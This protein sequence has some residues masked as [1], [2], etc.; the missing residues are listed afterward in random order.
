VNTAACGG[1]YVVWHE[2]RY[3]GELSAV[4]LRGDQAGWH[5][6]AIPELLVVVK[7]RLGE[8]TNQLWA[9][10]KLEG[11]NAVFG[12]QGFVRHGEPLNQTL[13]GCPEDRTARRP[14]RASASPSHRYLGRSL[15]RWERS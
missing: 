4:G 7:S 10:G 2:L 5:Q 6:A 14:S 1:E 12:V 15:S 13:V 8:L 9:H 3:C 11:S